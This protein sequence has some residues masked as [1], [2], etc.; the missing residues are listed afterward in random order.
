MSSSVKP[1]PEGYHTVTPHIILSNAREA[2]EFYQKALGAEIL[3]TMPGPG[4]SVM[5]GEMKIGDSVVM[6]CDEFEQSKAFSPSHY[7]GTPVMLMVYTEDVDALF[8]RAVNAGAR[9]IMAPEDMFWGD[10]FATVIDPYGHQWNLATHREDLSPEEMAE[11]Q[12]THF[13][14]A[15]SEGCQEG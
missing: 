8:E 14:K 13:E 5:H 11:R 10:R 2:A 3:F 7:G 1:I 6:F 4:D 9:V 15:Q 12:K